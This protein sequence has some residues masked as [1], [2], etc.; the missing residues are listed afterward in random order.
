MTTGQMWGWIGGI[1]GGLI[2]L[3][4]GAVGAYLSIKNTGGPRERMFMIKMT[5]AAV[6]VVAIQLTL[7][8]T[9]PHPQRHLV[10]VS[11]AVLLPIAIVF[12][13]R[14]QRQIA[15][16]ESQNNTSEHIP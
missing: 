6:I 13:N 2:G 4:G 7:L 15:Q 16:E 8:F 1:A 12:G 11:T 5:I 3:A 10:A 9:L 14:K